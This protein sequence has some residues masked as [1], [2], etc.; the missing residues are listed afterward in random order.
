MKTL[1]NILKL[2]KSKKGIF[3]FLIDPEKVKVSELQNLVENAQQNGVDLFF[4]GGSTINEIDF[5]NCIREIKKYSKIPVIIFPG[6]P[7]QISKNC[8]ALLFLSLISGRNPKHLIDSHVYAA[9]KIK[10]M[11]IEVIPTAYILIDG[12][13]E[14]TVQRISETKPIKQKNIKS[15]L[16][17]SLA[18]EFLGFKLIYLEA[19][20]GA[21]KSVSSKIISSVSRYCNLPIIVGGGIKTPAIAK[22]KIK[23]GASI[24]VIGNYFETK[25]N[26]NRLEQFSTAIHK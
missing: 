14:T 15:I 4:V 1:E 16:A 7:N 11:N 8:D 9:P 19:G 26:R 23:S 10:E 18:A 2:K 12:N 13:V 22:S 5:E 17:H 6:H 24:V 21:K 25:K 3:A 20:S